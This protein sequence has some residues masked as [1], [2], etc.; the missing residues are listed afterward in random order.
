MIL[1]S[2]PQYALVQEPTL[3]P[4]IRIHFADFPYSHYSTKLKDINLGYL[5][6]FLVRSCYWIQ[7][8]TQLNLS[9]VLSRKLNP[10][11]ENPDFMTRIQPFR[12]VIDFKGCSR[13]AQRIKPC[14]YREKITP[15]VSEQYNF[16]PVGY[17]LQLK[18]SNTQSGIRILS[19][20][21]FANTS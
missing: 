15:L 3:I 4:K 21:P 13:L 11:Y 1:S 18:V 17:A 12:S 2:I 8:A 5:M 19:Y 6:R 16:Q 20:F 14:H 7:D 9:S 10:L